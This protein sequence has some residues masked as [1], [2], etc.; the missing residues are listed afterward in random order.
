MHTVRGVGLGGGA[1]DGVVKVRR[2]CVPVMGGE[3]KRGVETELVGAG[4]SAEWRGIIA[5]NTSLTATLQSLSDGS[6]VGDLQSSLRGD[7]QPTN[8]FSIMVSNGANTNRVEGS[9]QVRSSSGTSASDVI[10]RVPAFAS[11]TIDR[12]YAQENMYMAC[13][14]S[15]NQLAGRDTVLMAVGLE[16]STMISFRSGSPSFMRVQAGVAANIVQGSTYQMLA[17]CD[18]SDYPTDDQVHLLVVKVRVKPGRVRVWIDGKQVGVG[19]APSGNKLRDGEWCDDKPGNFMFNGTFV[20]YGG[21]SFQPWPNVETT[22]FSDFYFFDSKVNIQDIPNQMV[23]KKSLNWTNMSLLEVENTTEMSG[24]NS[25]VGCKNASM[26]A[27]MCNSLAEEFFSPIMYSVSPSI[28]QFFGGNIIKVFLNNNSFQN[29]TISTNFL[30]LKYTNLTLTSVLVR[31]PSFSQ[32]GVK[33]NVTI[34]ILE[35]DSVVGYF[36]IVFGPRPTFIF[37]N[38]FFEA[39]QMVVIS[40][41]LSV[42]V[43]LTCSFFF[44]SKPAINFTVTNSELTRAETV[45]PDLQIPS[46]SELIANCS[47]DLRHMNAYVQLVNRPSMGNVAV[48]GNLCYWYLGCS[49]QVVMNSFFGDIKSA[50]L[51]VYKMENQSMTISTSF[52]VIACTSESS[53]KACP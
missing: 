17:Y 15:M 21:T 36:L 33:G 37:P 43:N 3:E 49:I 48:I 50:S 8:H 34:S 5:R 41:D 7:F 44:G 39:G 13:A 35:S 16:T 11:F 20:S 18:I 19:D 53:N 32:I 23:F 45:V 12:T 9:P 22:I 2:N 42:F 25:S 10:L 27:S 40:S 6:K 47:G 14:L 46:R 52:K 30:S 28:C 31:C 4:V 1:S 26:N 38:I 29:L 24:S 51:Q